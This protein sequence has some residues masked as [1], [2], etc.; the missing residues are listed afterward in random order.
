MAVLDTA[1][2]HEETLRHSA[3]DTVAR[4]V[5]I[6]GARLVAVIGDVKQT[7]TVREWIE[8]Q[9]PQGNR[10]QILRFA[11][12]V[13]ETIKQHYGEET[14]QSWFQGLNHHLLDRA[15]ALVLKSANDAQLDVVLSEEKTVLDALRNFLE[16]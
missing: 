10:L 16:R 5:E 12:Q 9:G 14:A 3:G 1:T 6:L 4:L 15:P 11:L 8:G 13:A 2:L 7:R